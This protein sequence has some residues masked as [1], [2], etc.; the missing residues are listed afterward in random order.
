MNELTEEKRYA[1]A[2]ALLLRQ[3]AQSFDDAGEMLIRQVRKLEARAHQR[4]RNASRNTWRKPQ[5]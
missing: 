2:A 5:A 4:S 1:L 3:R